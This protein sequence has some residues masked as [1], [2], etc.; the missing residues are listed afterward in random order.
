MSLSLPYETQSTKEAAALHW[1]QVYMELI[2]FLA[3]LGEPR[4][5]HTSLL[6]SVRSRTRDNSS[7]WPHSHGRYRPCLSRK[8]RTGHMVGMVGRRLRLSNISCLGIPGIGQAPICRCSDWLIDYRESRKR[9]V[10]RYRS[11]GLSL[12]EGYNET[13]DREHASEMGGMVTSM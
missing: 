11:H 7:S 8:Y 6:T 12:T 4:Q 2:Q 13:P 9:I 1:S 5:D 10:E 3:L